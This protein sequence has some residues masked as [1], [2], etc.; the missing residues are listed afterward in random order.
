MRRELIATGRLSS[1]TILWMYTTYGAH[2]T[3]ASAALTTQSGSLRLPPLAVWLGRG[4][5]VAG[6]GMAVAGMRRFAGPGQVSGTDP[7]GLVTTGIYRISRNP[8]YIGY[9]LALSGLTLARRSK[10]AAALTLAVAAVY[11]WWIPIEE[12]H[13]EQHFGS[14]YRAY[15]AHTRRWLGRPQR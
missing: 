2:A 10:D 14:G 7:G 9:L 4:L 1:S 5:V 13:L 3:A 6:T 8:Q 11:R 15:R 12:R